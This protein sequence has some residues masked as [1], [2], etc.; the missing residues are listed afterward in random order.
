M[1]LGTAE[2]SIKMGG[3]LARMLAGTAAAAAATAAEA[4]ATCAGA[5]SDGTITA[6]VEGT[7]FA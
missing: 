3:G 5:A 2:A 1:M 7:I 4:P 6:T